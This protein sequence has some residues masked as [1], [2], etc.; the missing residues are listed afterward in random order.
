MEHPLINNI[1]N[2]SL[3]ELQTRI[4]DLNKKLAWSYR[5]GNA[6]LS[7]QIQMALETFNVKYREKEK[8]LYD[9][10]RKNGP[11]YADKIDI[12]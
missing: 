11:D 3:E 8:A 6:H 9:A 2:M 7:A 10:S 1:D 12:S 5:T 4:T